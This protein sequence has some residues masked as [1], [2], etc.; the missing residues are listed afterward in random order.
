[1]PVPHAHLA[2]ML[3]S[4]FARSYNI[5]DAILSGFDPSVGVAASA[6]HAPMG[7][8]WHAWATPRQVHFSNRSTGFDTNGTLS[9]VTF[10]LDY[11]LTPDLVVGLAFSPE[12]TRVSFRGVGASL[13]Q[14]GFGGGPY[15]GWRL[16][17][18][19]IFDAW[20]GYVRLDRSFDVFRHGAT[21][22]VDRVFVSASLTEV[23]ETPWLRFLP[24]LTVFHARDEVRSA[25]SDFGFAIPGKGYNWGH[26]E[27]ALE[28]NRDIAL[29][30]GVLV[31]PFLSAALRYDT[32]RIVDVVSTLD[33][34]D[35]ELE[36][37]HGQLR[38]GVRAR[39]G[40]Q[41]EL[42]LSGG[43]L[44]LFTPDIEAWEAKAHFRVRF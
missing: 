14:T 1:M 33:G 38:G 2:R 9:E 6:V 20:L 44:S 17:P 8:Q 42:W 23:I 4:D 22:P 28:I 11:R 25:T 27:A 32:K 21:L 16:R 7:Q 15:L 36:R 40:P 12:Q 43:Y 18:T 37:W 30:S 13:D 34:A 31:Q 41:S 19:T 24:R 35:V 3:G 10:G 39:L 26:V 5:S 29:N